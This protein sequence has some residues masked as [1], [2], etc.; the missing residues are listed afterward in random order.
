MVNW[1]LTKITPLSSFD[2]KVGTLA[3]G[4]PYTGDL[5]NSSM[6]GFFVGSRQAQYKNKK[7]YI[8]N[9][10]GLLSDYIINDVF[11]NMNI[12]SGNWKITRLDWQLT[13]DA[14]LLL[15]EKDTIKKSLIR[16]FYRN[17]KDD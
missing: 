15:N 4:V 16:D 6:G 17:F 13:L 12:L 8:V 11:N 14:A 10:P 9:I 5:Y 7:E 1:F 2:K 3:W